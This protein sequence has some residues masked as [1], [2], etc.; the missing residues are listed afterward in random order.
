MEGLVLM[1]LY[2]II[3]VSFWYYPVSATPV[4]RFTGSLGYFSCVSGGL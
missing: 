1:M 2:L 3:A 4:H